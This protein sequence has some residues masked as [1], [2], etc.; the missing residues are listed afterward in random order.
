[1]SNIKQVKLSKGLFG[2]D[3]DMILTI[4]ESGDFYKY[5]VE[6]S[7]GAFNM[8]YNVSVPA[9]VIESLIA[10]GDV[11]VVNTTIADAINFINEKIEE[12]K[13]GIIDANK[14]YNN[15]LLQPCVKVELET[16]NYNM[17]K[18]L[19]KVRELLENE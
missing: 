17:I 9:E 18:V 16:V 12:Y 10:S 2:Y 7:D 14:D 15:G 11:E 3:E 8:S 13:Q 5:T 4:D 6:K 19:S 1:M